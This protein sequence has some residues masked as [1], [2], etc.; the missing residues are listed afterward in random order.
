MN[1]AETQVSTGNRINQPSDDPAGSA[2]L[3]Q[4]TGEQ[5]EM[6]L[7]MSNAQSAQNQ[8]SYTDT[9]LS[10]V[11]S[12]VQQAITTGELALSNSQSA[13]EDVTQINSLRDQV[14]S[15][16]NTAYQGTF[17]F[18][19]T[20]TNTQPYVEQSD[21]SV[22]YQGNSSAPQV[23]IGRATTLQTQIPGSQVF[24]GSVNVFDSLQQLSS[25]INS[26]DTSAIQ[27]Q[28]NNLQQYYNSIS[29]VRAQVGSLTNS[30]QDTQT[31]ITAYQTALTTDQ[32]RV[33]S[34]DMAQAAT[35]LTQ[36]QN[37]LQAAL[38]AGARISQVSLLDYIN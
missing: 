13:A 28:V 18:G 1:T 21:G 19:G 31:D 16:A 12:T 27:A 15:S 26:G 37:A 29:A 4:L 8:L 5:S 3:V 35:N 25:A 2:D 14:L 23:Q 38:E 30:A 17:L 7:Y 11:Q 10:G 20:V 33:Q 24:S 6:S 36:T 32:S 9:V 22:T 34:A